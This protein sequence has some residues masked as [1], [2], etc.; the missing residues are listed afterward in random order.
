MPRQTKGTRETETKTNKESETMTTNTNDTITT[1]EIATTTQTTHAVTIRSFADTMRLDLLT[2][3]PA[4][5]AAAAKDIAAD[6]FK[7]MIASECGTW[8]LVMIATFNRIENHATADKK[9]AEKITVQSELLSLLNVQPV[10]ESIG[11]EKIT[12]EMLA[13]NAIPGIRS[14]YDATRTIE[15]ALKLGAT[16][17]AEFWQEYAKASRYSALGALDKLCDRM[18]AYNKVNKNAAAAF[19][20]KPITAILNGLLVTF[21]NF[22]A[23]K[24]A[25]DI[26]TTPGFLPLPTAKTEAA[27]TE[28]AERAPQLPTGTRDKD[29]ERAP[30][31]PTGTRD[32]DAADAL[33][34][35]LAYCVPPMPEQE[36]KNTAAALLFAFTEYSGQKVTAYD[37][38]RVAC[39]NVDKRAT[40][41]AAA[42][43]TP[44]NAEKR[45]AE[46]IA[47]AKTEAAELKAAAN[48]PTKRAAANA[49]TKRA[50]K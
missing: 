21:K 12:A 44:T 45:A 27:K 2:V 20:G 19:D 26:A 39:R 47:A 15:R 16:I 9:V 5:R 43:D 17:P 42:V 13:G 29:A 8:N 36:T 18:I 28:A 40:T 6:T 11:V 37:V 34:A 30:Q 31:L 50:A 25:D 46:I 35:A 41:M 14:I 33:N 3:A 22:T 7:S 38:L 49:P 23:A 24:A 4:E 32:K 1:N 10:L 48:A